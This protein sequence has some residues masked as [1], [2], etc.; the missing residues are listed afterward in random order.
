M[1]LTRPGPVDNDTNSNINSKNHYKVIVAAGLGTVV[2]WYDYALFGAAAGLVIGPLFFPG[3]SGVVGLLAALATFSVGFV[4]RPIGGIIVS[5]IGDRFGRKRAVTLTIILMGIG[6][7]GIGLL[8][9]AES[10]GIMA[11]ILLVLFRAIQGFGAGAELT[12]AFV[13]VAESV[14]K[15]RRGAVTGII[16]SCS[17]VGI[18][19]A[20]FVF[21]AVSSLPEEAF[22]SWGW[23]IPFLISAL[24]FILALYIRRS[25]DETPEFIDSLDRSDESSA[26]D[27]QPVREVA[28]TQP[29]AL[30]LG[31]LVWTGQNCLG[32]IM[33]IF[34]LAYLTE[35]VDMS[36]TRALIIS[37][38]GG[39]V[40]IVLMPLFGHFGDKIGH[41]NILTGSMVAT[42]AFAWPFFGML[43]SGIFWVC[44]A[45]VVI[46]EGVIVSSA[47]G[48]IGAVT[49]NLFPPRTRYTGMTLGKEMNAALIAGPT[50]FIATALLAASGGHPWPV[51]VFVASMAAISLVALII[52]QQRSLPSYDEGV[53]NQ[54][55]INRGQLK[56]SSTAGVNQ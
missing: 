12:G 9:T 23:R 24:L 43:S 35:F 48:V 40:C 30:I 17:L 20:T 41:R 54:K 46:G 1:K 52:M 38:A 51:A 29:H 39:L 6:T 42:I 50:P 8:P 28:R 27:R 18:L 33:F 11:P 2:E 53:T 4:V 45:A 3:Q 49:T 44:L 10:I 32:Y 19:L 37:A 15:R 31:F 26:I 34:T 7:T 14:P 25:L 36:R 21:L 22:M 55:D 47:S 16:N 5:G 13:L 56:P